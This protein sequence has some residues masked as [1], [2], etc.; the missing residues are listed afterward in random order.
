[1]YYIILILVIFRLII[2][3]RFYVIIGSI[4]ISYHSKMRNSGRKIKLTVQRGFFEFFDSHGHWN[5]KSMDIP[6]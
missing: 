3:R 2:R 5:M 6:K 1:M 4:I